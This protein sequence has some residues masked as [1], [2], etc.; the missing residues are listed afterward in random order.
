MSDASKF[1][2]QV[3]QAAATVVAQHADEVDRQARFPEASLAALKAIGALGL[4]SP[5]ELGGL[6]HGHREAALVVERL[7]RECSSTA[8][9]MAC[10]TR[11]SKCQ[12]AE[13]PVL[14]TRKA[15]HSRMVS[16][17]LNVTVVS[18]FSAMSNH[19]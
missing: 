19:F 12:L 2:E 14:P 6:G 9:V 10:R 13:W 11:F 18:R 7:A 1:L 4:I 8:M 16:L 17:V 5:A 15:S 3:D